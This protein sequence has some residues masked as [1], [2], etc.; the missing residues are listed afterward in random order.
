MKTIN[1]KFKQ[2]NILNFSTRD[3]TVELE[4]LFNNYKTIKSLVIDDPEEIANNL[5]IEI[6]RKVKEINQRPASD[7]LLD[8][9]LT[10]I[11]ENEERIIN[12]ISMFLAKLSDKIKEIK[13]QTQS[14]NYLNSMNLI[15]SMKLEF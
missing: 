3:E 6:R 15:K 12:K 5:I 10:I 8:N 11:I 13:N 9:I 1:V 14:G 7:N 2:I 4:I